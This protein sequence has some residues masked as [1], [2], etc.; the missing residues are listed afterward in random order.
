MQLDN[1]EP[2]N[3]I[4]TRERL[5]SGFSTIFLATAL[6]Q[7][8]VMKVKADCGLFIHFLEST[9]CR[10]LKDQGL[11]DY[12][13]LPNFLGSL[14]EFDSKLCSLY[15]DIPQYMMII[16]DNLESV[17]YMDS[18][19]AKTYNHDSITNKERILLKKESR[20]CHRI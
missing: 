10:R 8:C 5:T 9:A 17:I 16:H 20:E 2:C 11:Y 4:F 7:A 15:L 19:R 12:G 3:N 6:N 1:V 14:R 13:I 18:D